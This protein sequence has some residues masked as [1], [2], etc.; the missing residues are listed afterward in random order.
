MI[1]RRYHAPVR[2]LAQTYGLSRR[3]VFR[4]LAGGAG[5]AVGGEK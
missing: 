2:M 5:G 4:I 3:S 1:R